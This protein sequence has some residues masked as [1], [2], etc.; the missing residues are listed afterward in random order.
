MLAWIGREGMLRLIGVVCRGRIPERM[1]GWLVGWLVGGCKGGRNSLGLGI[2][3]WI[4]PGF[5]P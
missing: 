2:S 4:W 1:D 5:P 3:C